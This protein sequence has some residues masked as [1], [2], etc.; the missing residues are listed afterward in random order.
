MSLSLFSHITPE[1]TKLTE[2]IRG[3]METRTLLG[4]ENVAENVSLVENA[5]KSHQQHSTVKS[6]EIGKV[7]K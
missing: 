3:H 7:M 2:I 6:W 1:L 5:L 4:S